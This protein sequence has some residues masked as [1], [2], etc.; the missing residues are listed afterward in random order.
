M[1]RFVALALAVV[2]CLS[3]CACG[4]SNKKTVAVAGVDEQRVSIGNEDFYWSAKGLI[5]VK[6]SDN[7]APVTLKVSEDSR[8]LTQMPYRQC[9]QVDDTIY[10]KYGDNHYIYSFEL[11]KKNENE[12]ANEWL[13]FEDEDYM[14]LQSAVDW[15]YADG[16]IY[17]YVYLRLEYAESMSDKIYK[18]MRINI[19]TKEIETVSQTAAVCSYVVYNDYIYYCDNGYYSES[20]TSEKINYDQENAGIYRMKTDGSSQEKLLDYNPVSDSGSYAYPYGKLSIY[21]D[22]LYF[23]DSSDLSNTVLCSMALD[24]TNLVKLSD[25]SVNEFTI[26]A[27]SDK[28]YYM[29]GKFN[30][31][32][33]DRGGDICEISLDGQNKKLL[34]KDEFPGTTRALYAKD[35]KLYI[36][37][38]Y[39]INNTYN[40][41]DEPWEGG[42]VID[43]KKGNIKALY[44][45]CEM[46]EEISQEGRYGNETKEVVDKEYFYWAD[47]TGVQLTL[48]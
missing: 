33:T 44:S 13:S 24:G 48:Y 43:T 9:V 23:I 36:Y 46:K 41:Q 37:L 21:G 8:F 16:Y 35:G 7:L 12:V 25:D 18:L 6:D 22:V 42:Y 17:F 47:Y 39:N 11:D 28:I 45:Y 29:T 2:L 40:T 20:G 3:F 34:A 26:D 15:Q 19:D 38:P 5:S 30:I 4:S 1:K 27:Y 10:F 31:A 14:L 32:T